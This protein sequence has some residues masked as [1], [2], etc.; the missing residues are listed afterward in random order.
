MGQYHHPVCIEV[1]EGLNPAGM[2]SGLKEGEQGFSRPRS[3]SELWPTKGW[4]WSAE[5]ADFVALSRDCRRGR[6]RGLVQGI[7]DGAFPA[8]PVPYAAATIAGCNRRRAA[9]SFR[10][11]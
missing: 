2:D 7:G 6:A 9:A 4:L 5:I 8:F 3:P 11:L 10:R 1:E